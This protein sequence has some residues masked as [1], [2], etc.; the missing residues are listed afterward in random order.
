MI[1]V[2]NYPQAGRRRGTIVS[3]VSVAL[4]ALSPSHTLAQS[5]IVNGGFETADFTGWTLAGDPATANYGLMPWFAPYFEVP[6]HTGVYSAYFAG[7]GTFD[8]FSQTVTTSVGANYTLDFYMQHYVSSPL[9]GNSSLLPPVDGFEV[10]VDA[11]TDLSVTSA[12]AFGYTEYSYAFT[13][14]GSDTLTFGGAS[15][16]GLYSMDDVSIVYDASPVTGTPEPG[17]MALL[18]GLGLSG[19]VYS[20]RWS[21]KR[22]C[23]TDFKPHTRD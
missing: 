11:T 3:F 13:G 9:G 14:T 1:S 22:T 6:S 19:G 16:F 2:F 21:R 23:R 8:T 17:S 12:P 15:T 4:L 5:L 20:R 18:I 10:L 7:F